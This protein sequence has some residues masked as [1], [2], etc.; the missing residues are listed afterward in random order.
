M[1][2]GEEKQWRSRISSSKEHLES[3]PLLFNQNHRHRWRF[4]VPAD[5]ISSKILPPWLIPSF[6]RLLTSSADRGNQPPSGGAQSSPSF[7]LGIITEN[8]QPF[9]IPVCTRALRKQD[10]V[11]SAA[12]HLPERTAPT[13]HPNLTISAGDGDSRWVSDAVCYLQLCSSRE[14]LQQTC[15]GDKL[16]Q[17]A[18]VEGAGLAEALSWTTLMQLQGFSAYS[19]AR[20]KGELKSRAKLHKIRHYSGLEPSRI[21]PPRCLGKLMRKCIQDY[22]RIRGPFCSKLSFT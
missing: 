7:Q 6:N 10:S 20:L 1:K 15:Q 2:K 3:F 16:N 17:K 9:I 11:I 18:D 5:Y 4:M 13:L 19:E 21:S 12:G 22:S 8:P 14:K